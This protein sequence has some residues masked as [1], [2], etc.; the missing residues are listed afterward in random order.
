MLSSG[1]RARASFELGLFDEVVALNLN[2]LGR[3]GIR[4]QAADV[5]F[6]ASEEWQEIVLPDRFRQRSAP[7]ADHTGV[8]AAHRIVL[9]PFARD[10]YA[11]SSQERYGLCRYW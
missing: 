2:A 3:Q 7:H 1:R 5:I 10:A 4:E 9:G 11:K 6:E 8:D